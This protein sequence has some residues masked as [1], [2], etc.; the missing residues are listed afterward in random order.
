MGLTEFTGGAIR[1]RDGELSHGIDRVNPVTFEDGSAEA[2]SWGFRRQ[3]AIDG[4]DEEGDWLGGTAHDTQQ[5]TRTV[6][7]YFPPTG[8]PAPTEPPLIKFP[9]GIEPAPLPP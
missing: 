4:N 6:Q 3:G 8:T 7:R 9:I 5:A 1:S 2:G